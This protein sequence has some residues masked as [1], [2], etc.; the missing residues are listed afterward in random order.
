MVVNASDGVCSCFLLKSLVASIKAQ[1]LHELRGKHVTK[2]DRER[3]SRLIR[4]YGWQSEASAGLILGIALI[5]VSMFPSICM[6]ESLTVVSV[7]TAVRLFSKSRGPARASCHFP[8]QNLMGP[9][10]NHQPSL[11]RTTKTA[12][13]VTLYRNADIG[14]V[15]MRTSCLSLTIVEECSW[16][17]NRE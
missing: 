8:T 5:L 1:R 2:R 16:A 3:R 9:T 10:C 13:P 15:N 6:V 11:V 17:R 12:V 14:I 7:A 4:V